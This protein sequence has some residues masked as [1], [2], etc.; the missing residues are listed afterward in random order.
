VSI[1]LG[2]GG[3]SFENDNILIGN[4]ILGGFVEGNAEGSSGQQENTSEEEDLLDHC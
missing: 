4:D 2:L 1:A 3:I